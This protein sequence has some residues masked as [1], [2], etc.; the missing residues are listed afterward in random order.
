[1][2]ARLVLDLRRFEQFAAAMGWETKG[3]AA[4]ALGMSDVQLYRIRLRNTAP[5][6]QFIGRLL[7]LALATGKWDFHDLFTV[8][9]ED[10]IA[11]PTPSEPVQDVA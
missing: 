4:K 11:L 1:M 3:D 5:S 9:G 8:L 2:P 7:A 10:G 6:G